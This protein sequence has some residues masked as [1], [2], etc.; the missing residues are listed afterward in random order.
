M[1]R[2]IRALNTRTYVDPDGVEVTRTI[3]LQTMFAAAGSQELIPDAVAMIDEAWRS[4]FGAPRSRDSIDYG[5]FYARSFVL[6]GDTREDADHAADS[7]RHRQCTG[8]SRDPL[9]VGARD[10]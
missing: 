6:C 4:L 7:A 2:V 8:R 10:D 3:F 9:G 1:N 5:Y